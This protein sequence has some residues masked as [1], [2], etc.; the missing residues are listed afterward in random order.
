VAL[1]AR[2]QLRNLLP[3]VVAQAIGRRSASESADLLR[4]TQSPP[5]ES[6]NR[7]HALGPIDIQGFTRGLMRD[8]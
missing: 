5:W 4:I 8:S 1:T 6:D 7:G 3:W 2:Q